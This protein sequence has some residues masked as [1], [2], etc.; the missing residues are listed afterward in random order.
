[1]NVRHKMGYRLVRELAEDGDNVAVACRVLMVSRS[2]YNE[3]CQRPPSAHDFADAYL[4]NTIRHLSCCTDITEHPTRAG[5]ITAPRSPTCS[6]PHLEAF[7]MSRD[8]LPAS[9]GS[10]AS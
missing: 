6:V 4:A 5:E 10:T 2:G 1:M 8:P 3:W 9:V 7:A